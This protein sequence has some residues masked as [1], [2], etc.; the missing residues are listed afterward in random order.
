MAADVCEG[1]GGKLKHSTFR[2][3][4]SLLPSNALQLIKASSAVSRDTALSFA[5]VRESSGDS[6]TRW[7]IFMAAGTLLCNPDL[8]TVADL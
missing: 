4:L 5:I 8:I 7:N 6:C 3:H 2:K 1:F